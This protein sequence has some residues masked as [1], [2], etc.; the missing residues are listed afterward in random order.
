MQLLLSI[1][2]SLLPERYRRPIA[3]RLHVDPTRGAFLSGL[4]ECVTCVALFVFRYIHFLQF[5][6]GRFAEELVRH[7][8][9]DAMGE[10]SVQWGAGMVSLGEYL[11]QPLTLLLVY[12]AF[13]GV[14][15][16]SAALIHGEQE[17]VPT[18]P[19]QLVA[20]AHAGVLKAK[21]RHDLGPLVADEVQQDGVNPW[22]R[23][24]TCRPK[25][26]N[27]LTTVA[28]DKKLYELAKQEEG[29]APRPYVYVLRPRPEHKVIRGLCEYEPDELVRETEGEE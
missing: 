1:L 3:H 24:A 29:T 22:V 9:E 18:L 12:F 15:R 28:Y 6:V 16:L 4:A 23:I 5:R 13:E 14:V 2:V 11:I 21:H 26:W 27:D 10:L 17:I 25:P 8:A 19:L 7:N 20:W